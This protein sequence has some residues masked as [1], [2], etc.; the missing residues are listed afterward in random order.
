MYASMFQ[1]KIKKV[2]IFFSAEYFCKSL[3]KA[4]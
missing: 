3:P 4:H 1:D 2:Y